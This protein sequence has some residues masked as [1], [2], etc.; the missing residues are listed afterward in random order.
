[1]S[2]AAGLCSEGGKPGSRCVYQA[3]SG[4]GPSLAALTAL[5]SLGLSASGSTRV[6]LAATRLSQLWMTRNFPGY[7]SSVRPLKCHPL[8]ESQS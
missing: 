6:R 8:H 1:M 2:R 5:L 4:L 3:G 7:L